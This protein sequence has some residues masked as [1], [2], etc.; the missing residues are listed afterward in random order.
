MI[1]F[2]LWQI[3]N[4]QHPMIVLIIGFW[5]GI[6]GMVFMSACCGGISSLK[7]VEDK[8]FTC[9]IL[10]LISSL[11]FPFWHVIL[12]ITLIYFSVELLYR[13]QKEW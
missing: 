6:C 4:I 12:S 11:L 8:P 10:F 7:I 1:D 13:I 9:F 2:I 3:N 5:I